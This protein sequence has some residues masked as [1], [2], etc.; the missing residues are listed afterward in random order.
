[1]STRRIVTALLAL[2]LAACGT[3]TVLHSSFNAEP[4]GSA[5]LRDQPVGTVLSANGGGSVTIAPRAGSAAGDH[6]GWVEIRHPFTTS[7]TELRARFDAAHGTG[8]YTLLAVLYIPSGAGPLT[9]QLEGLGDPSDIYSSVD[10]LRLDFLPGHRV[11]YTTYDGPA[12]LGPFPPDAEILVSVS[13]D[14]TVAPAIATV[15]ILH[16]TT[17]LAR[18]ENVI[19]PSRATDFGSVRVLMD[20][21]STGSVFVDDIVVTRKDM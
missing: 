15:S 5:P 14:S 8:K 19:L 12:P 1:M 11:T 6:P 3:T 4:A 10:F 9:L 13:F 21:P 16:G 2:S 7:R 20:E 17:V 18:N